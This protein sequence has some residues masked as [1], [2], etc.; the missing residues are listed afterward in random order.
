MS[1]PMLSKRFIS[2]KP[3][4]YSRGFAFPTSSLRSTYSA[5]SFSTSSISRASEPDRGAFEGPYSQ[6]EVPLFDRLQ[7]FP[8]SLTLSFRQSFIYIINRQEI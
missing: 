5:P 3:T 4:Y 1:I 6:A 2:I 7:M 8:V